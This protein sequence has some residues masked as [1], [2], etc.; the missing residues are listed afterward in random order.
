M[1]SIRLREFTRHV[2]FLPDTNGKRGRHN[3][4]MNTA[5]NLQT[6]LSTFDQIWSPRIVSQVNDY[7]VRIAKV[8][9]EHVWHVHDNTDEFFLVIEGQFNIALRDAAGAETAVTLNPGEL[10]TVPRGTYHRP[11]SPDGASILMFEPT[12]TSTTGDTHDEIPDHVHSTTG[13]LT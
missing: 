6:A 8:M 9:G 11:F 12:G 13:Q 2:P 1:R 10:F 5:V 3:C 7:D 4:V